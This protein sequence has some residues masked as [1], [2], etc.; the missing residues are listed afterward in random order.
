MPLPISDSSPSSRRPEA[1]ACTAFRLELSCRATASRSRRYSITDSRTHGLRL[2][3]GLTFEATRV[4]IVSQNSVGCSNAPCTP[5]KSGRRVSADEARSSFT[6]V[7]VGKL[8][9]TSHTEAARLS[10]RR[11]DLMVDEGSVVEPPRTIMAMRTVEPTRSIEVP[12]AIEPARSKNWSAVAEAARRE[13]RS[14]AVGDVRDL[15]VTDDGFS[16]RDRQRGSICRRGKTNAANDGRGDGEHLS[17]HLDVT[18]CETRHS[19]GAGSHRLQ[20][21]C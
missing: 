20:H 10:P 16:R 18:L 7:G 2:S 1:I 4:G 21:V 15:S 13:A 3:A 17:T 12:R 11:W 14:A 5:M 8:G 6:Q 9:L 19:T